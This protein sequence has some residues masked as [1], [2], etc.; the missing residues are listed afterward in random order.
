MSAVHQE[1]AGLFNAS[2]IGLIA[3]FSI[4]YAVIKQQK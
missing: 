4:Y 3:P 1:N 2:V